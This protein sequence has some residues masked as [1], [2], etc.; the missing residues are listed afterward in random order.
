MPLIVGSADI[1]KAY[2][3]LKQ[4]FLINSIL[5]RGVPR[6]LIACWIRLLKGSTYNY[7]L[8]DRTASGFFSKQRSVDQGDTA[9]RFHFVACA[10]DALAGTVTQWE[11]GRRGVTLDDGTCITHFMFADNIWPVCTTVEDLV[12]KISEVNKALK[13]AG[14]QLKMNDLHWCSTPF[15]FDAVGADATLEFE[16]VGVKMEDRRKGLEILG[17]F[18]PMMRRTTTEFQ[19][20]LNK[21]WNAFWSHKAKWDCRMATRVQRVKMLDRIIPAS[22]LYACQT[23]HPTVKELIQL[24]GAQ[25][26]MWIITL[27]L[28][29]IWTLSLAENAKRVRKFIRETRCACGLTSWGCP[30]SPETVGICRTC[31]PRRCGPC[32][33]F[34]CAL[35]RGGVAK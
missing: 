7:I 6:C 24:R 35:A 3:R 26:R 32:A 28:P 10:D 23:W 25:Q 34:H 13:P 15:C 9:A 20:R 31:V 33:T 21:A 1:W 4:A 16:G 8:D 5:K 11:L 18:C 19:H 22:L 2:D 30:M 17:S 29:H 27:K 14:W 12:R